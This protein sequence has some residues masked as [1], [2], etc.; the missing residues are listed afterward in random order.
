MVARTETPTPSMPEMD[1]LTSTSTSASSS[2]PL[3]HTTTHT[4]SHILLASTVAG[5]C[6]GACGVVVGFP[7]DTLKTRIQASPTGTIA[8]IPYSLTGLH[9]LYRGV[10]MP[11]ASTGI[12]QALNFAVY[13]SVKHYLT[14]N[15]HSNLSYLHT[16]FVAGAVSGGVM[17]LLATP[18]QV[19]KV[20]FQ[21]DLTMTLRKLSANLMSGRK[22]P[23]VALYRGYWMTAMGD[24]VGRGLYMYSYEGM[25]L[26]LSNHTHPHAYSS[27]VVDSNVSMSIKMLAAGFAGS[28]TWFVLFPIDVIKTRVQSQIYGV[29]G[30][31]HL[32]DIL[33]SS[34]PVRQL[35]RGCFYA[36]IRA[37]PVAAS[38]LPLYEYLNEEMLLRLAR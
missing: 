36:V 16:V 17:S 12:M 20:Q 6:A 26:L 22:V 15:N 18:I 34:Q 13:G 2:Q 31:D 25:K 5:M 33:R 8:P 27:T 10:A 23:L 11:L 35:Y 28:F 7:F 21:T 24:V 30:R 37:A 14:E 38:I 1:M 29:S 19:V 32:R 4:T 9:S 3:H